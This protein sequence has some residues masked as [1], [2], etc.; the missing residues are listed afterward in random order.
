MTPIPQRIYLNMAAGG[1]PVRPRYDFYTASGLVVPRGSLCELQLQA[2]NRHD[3]TVDANGYAE[4]AARFSLADFTGTPIFALKTA[5]Q[6]VGE[7]EFAA[8]FTGY[9]GTAWH[10][11]AAGR[12]GILV[13]A[14]STVDADLLH[15]G[16]IRLADAG[17]NFLIAPPSYLYVDVARPVILGSESAAPSGGV[18]ASG[19]ITIANGQASG[20]ATVTGLTTGAVV[21]ISQRDTGAGIVGA[22]W[23]AT[24]NTL[25]ITAGDVAPAATL[26][27]TYHVLSL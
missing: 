15:F 10:S 12:A 25:T 11:L 1:L 16:Q 19:T 21:S 4:T 3:F 26:Q 9:S 17:G 6:L 7:G 8:A 22:V 13:L 27:Y 23:A 2:V 18:L 20:T 14:T 5:A 24:T